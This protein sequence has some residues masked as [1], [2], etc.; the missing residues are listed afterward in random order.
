MRKLRML[1][2][3]NCPD[4]RHSLAELLR[5][6]YGQLVHVEVETAELAELD[7]RLDGSQD[8][9]IFEPFG[10]CD[11]H[12]GNINEAT[13]RYC[14]RLRAI[15]ARGAQSIVLTTQPKL[16]ERRPARALTKPVAATDLFALVSE[17]TGVVIP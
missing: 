3:D 14:R 17:A 8:L 12:A 5:A 10:P 15:G 11:S 16:A 6:F 2:V 13:E 1:I 4:N 9:V 7:A